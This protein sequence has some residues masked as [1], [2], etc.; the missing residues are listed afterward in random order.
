MQ[1]KLELINKTKD[2]SFEKYYSKLQELF[3]KTMKIHDMNGN[4]SLSLILVGPITIK[5]INREYRNKDSVTDVISFALLDSE[6]TYEFPLEETI[7]GDIFINL[8]RV[9]SR[10]IDYGHS[11]ER[12]FCFLFIH[13]LLH[14]LGYDHMNEEDEAK[15]IAMQKKIL[16]ERNA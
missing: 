15:M 16:G 9:K 11:E 8:K 10:A 5:R 6:D 14:C 4:Y 3:E 13:G 7:L 2:K 12:E 1:C